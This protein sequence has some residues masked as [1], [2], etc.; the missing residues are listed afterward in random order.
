VGL[1]LWLATAV[2]G[3]VGIILLGLGHFGAL[4]PPVELYVF[5]ATLLALAATLGVFNVTGNALVLLAL[6]GVLLFIL[7]GIEGFDW[8]G[9]RGVV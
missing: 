1:G 3:T 2:I 5:G 9:L 8:W 4:G 7:I 6:F